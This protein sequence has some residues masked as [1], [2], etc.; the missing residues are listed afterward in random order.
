MEIYPVDEENS[1]E[2]NFS[3]QASCNGIMALRERYLCRRQTTLKN[4]KRSL[5]IGRAEWN[6]GEDA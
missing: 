1:T 2:V 5:E 4:R 3:A 6:S